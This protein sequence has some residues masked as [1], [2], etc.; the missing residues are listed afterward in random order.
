MK[1]LRGYQ[2]EGVEFLRS[3][4]GGRALLCDEM[5]LGKSAT[6]IRAADLPVL[7]ICP[8]GL[9]L[10]WE[11]EVEM[12]R[13]GFG[14]AFTIRS[15]ADPG[16]EQ[17]DARQFATVIVDEAHY[18]KN[19]E[20]KRSLLVCRM[21]RRARRRAFALS[22]TL[23]PNRPIELWAILYAMRM[24]RLSYGEFADRYADAKPDFW[25]KGE[26]DVRGASNLEE[27][28]DLLRP[29][30]L[31]RTKKQVLPELPDKTW[32][33]VALNLPVGQREK[34]YSLDEIEKMDE[35]VAFEALSEVLH[36]HG[37][38]KLPAATDHLRRALEDGV[39]VVAFAYHKEVIAGLL[40]NLA[41]FNPVS[42]V[43]D[44]SK[45]RRQRAVDVF[46]SDPSCRLFVGQIK[47]A[48]VGW[49]LTAA[50]HVVF[51]EGS[52]VPADIDQAA[53]RCH[54]I[55][56]RMN[57][58]IDLLTI[59]KSIDEH[60]L[61]RA[62]EKL[63][64]IQRILPETD[65]KVCIP[66][67]PRG[68]IRHSQGTSR[69]ER[70]DD[71]R[72]KNEQLR[73]QA[74]FELSPHEDVRGLRGQPQDT[75]RKKELLSTVRETSESDLEGGRKTD[76]RPRLELQSTT[77]EEVNMKTSELAKAILLEAVRLVRESNDIG[78]MLNH[79]SGKVAG[80][81][82]AAEADEPEAAEAAEAAEASD[83]GQTSEVTKPAKRKKATRKKKKDAPGL[84]D[85]RAAGLPVIE[86]YGQEGLLQVFEE[87]GVK[88]IASL[89][90][91]K[92][93]EFIIACEKYLEEDG[94]A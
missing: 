80:A 71:G 24:T 83:D 46:Q 41:E 17:V 78:A 57:V 89:P 58:S 11:R 34:R 61:H 77:E 50:S 82:D 54:R 14:N 94:D 10:N 62:L 49:T 16:L 75:D 33:V 73:N 44:H 23:V 84:E 35:K 20:A 48:G 72:K 76:S 92:I 88:N 32:R 66:D 37:L 40:E 55:G 86:E 53:D 15:Y 6:A 56:Q 91:T 47:S 1:N 21:L 38:R 51:V 79:E 36:E 13:P 2:V 9:I 39:K 5:G 22:G 27:L 26:L 60:M 63:S 52:W 42:L 67:T 59:H 3:V 7:V 31:R 90:D 30:C 85:A 45:K 74:M 28:R 64:V 43:G 69:L 25:R 18:L 65:N 29:F 93:P 70:R 4:P 8:A 81:T 87:F 19:H 12:W 68:R